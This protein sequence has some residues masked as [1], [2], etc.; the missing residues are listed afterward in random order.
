[1]KIGS[2]LKRIRTE[3]CLTLRDLAESTNLSTGFLSNIERDINSPTI[4][5]L[6]KICK[7]V[8]VSLVEM[9]SDSN[10]NEVEE[11]IT[12]NNERVPV[13]SSRK[14]KIRY[15][16]I[17]GGRKNLKTYCIVVEPGGDYGAVSTLGHN[18]DEVGF[19]IEGSLEVTV[20]EET[21]MLEEGDSVYVY[22]NKQHKYRNI[23]TVRCVSLWIRGSN[24]DE[25][26]INYGK[27]FI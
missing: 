4:S 14:S 18:A 6:A 1:M 7:A 16:Q 17:W 15:E 22:A 3:R 21:Y 2:K 10:N 19:V 25:W 13:F 26:N 5:S 8:N 24:F 20:D 27:G 11:I 9:L 12:R 23:G